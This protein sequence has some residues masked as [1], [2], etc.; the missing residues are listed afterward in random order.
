MDVLGVNYC[1]AF[2]D[3]FINL[4]DDGPYSKVATLFI[5]SPDTEIHYT[6]DGSSPNTKSPVYAGPFVINKSEIVK[7]RGF[8]DSKPIGNETSKSFN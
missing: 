1:K 3:V 6:T 7:A 8:R 5:D 2:Y 4:T